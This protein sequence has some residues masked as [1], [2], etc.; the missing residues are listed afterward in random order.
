MALS[1]CVNI[2]IYGYLCI[3]YNDYS[4]YILFWFPYFSLFKILFYIMAY[5]HIIH[6]VNIHLSV[7]RTNSWA[8]VLFFLTN[9]IKNNYEH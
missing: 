9:T 8:F 2:K 4:G 1:E 6:H 7:K 3:V 5:L